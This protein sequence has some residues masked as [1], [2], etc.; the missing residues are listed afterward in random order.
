M[1]SRQ[2]IT[3][4][5]SRPRSESLPPLGSTN[6]T[7]PITT[8]APVYRIEERSRTIHIPSDVDPS[9]WDPH[10]LNTILTLAGV[11]ESEQDRITEQPIRRTKSHADGQGALSPDPLD[12]IERKHESVSR[13]S[14][15]RAQCPG[16]K[17]APLHP[18]DN[19]ALRDNSPHGST[20]KPSSARTRILFYRK[21]DPYYGFTNFSPH[22]VIYN[23]RKYPTSEH[24]FQSFKF[25]AHRPNLAEHIRTY[26]ER[27]SVAFSEARRFQ[28]EA[29]PDWEKMEVTLYHKFTQHFDLQAE[30]L[31]TGDAE[32]IENSDKDA[33]WGVGADGKGRNEL[34]KCLERLRAKLLGNGC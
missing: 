11:P 16:I 12:T 8:Q 21:D 33:F 10:M 23:G 1:F 29:R 32:L 2:T 25:Q 13:S 6:C 4:V 31:G 14:V 18:S 27:P 3:I 24:L 28:P 26:S 15:Y 9:Q 22:P 17:S 7:P 20:S 5:T 30:L 34:G 19:P